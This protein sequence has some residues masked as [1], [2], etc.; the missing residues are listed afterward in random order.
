MVHS[1]R[2]YRNQSGFIWTRE[3]S[4]GS[5]SREKTLAGTLCKLIVSENFEQWTSYDAVPC[6]IFRNVL[7]GRLRQRAFI[8]DYCGWLWRG[9]ALT[10]EQTPE[11]RSVCLARTFQLPGVLWA[12]GNRSNSWSTHNKSIGF[13]NE[14]RASTVVSLYIYRV[15]KFISR[16]NNQARKIHLMPNF[17]IWRNKKN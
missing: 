8:S 10:F 4:E 9:E 5:L 12:P 16:R 2:S 13:V 7:L 1:F 3:Y 17:K 6:D 11:T 14:S 15:K